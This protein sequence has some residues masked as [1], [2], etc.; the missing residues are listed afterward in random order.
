MQFFRSNNDNLS[1]NV[2]RAASPITDPITNA[3]QSLAGKV[4]FL[5]SADGAKFEAEVTSWNADVAKYV[6]DT[7]VQPINT[8]EVCLTVAAASKYGARLV[9]AGGRHGHDCLAEGA[10]VLDLSK[11]KAVHVD[12][13]KRLVTVEG[14]CKLGDM[15][16]A[17]KP[18]GLGCV[19]GT[20]PDTGVVGLST[21]GGG[22][23]LSRLHG[24]AVD[25][26]VSATVVL[27]N[28]EAITASKDE[29]ADLLWGLAGAGSNFGVVTS[30]TMRAHEVDQVFGGL[31]I[32]TAFTIRGANNVL[33]NWRDWITAAPRSLMSMAVLPCGAPV[34]PMVIAETDKA[35]VP[36][37]EGD[38]VRLRQIPS[39]CSLGRVGSFG[40]YASIKQMKR[41]QYHSELQAL[42]EPMQASGHYYDASCLVP[43]LSDEVI[44]TLTDFTRAQNVNK[45]ASI[46]IF[47]M[48]AA[49][50]DAPLDSTA[51]YG[52]GRKAGAFWIIIEGKF[53]PD[54]EGANRAAV[55]DWVKRLRAALAKFDVSD[56]AHT[57]DGNMES[58]LAGA[59][60]IFGPN[61]ERLRAVKA[62]YDPTNFFKCNRNIEPA[63]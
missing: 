2:T 63:A 38:S 53:E 57:L 28:G 18:H 44:A 9:I 26:F 35:V 23:Y 49:I 17:C 52:G 6:P 22:G 16:A 54:E 13:E 25:N 59:R 10:L 40:S 32:N 55:V 47:P 58:E 20:N 61:L 34:V 46:I 19:T 48:G 33:A 50:A 3:R 31:L 43:E 27:A 41:M 60:A 4:S 30:L 42:L 62:K 11:M 21:A 5:T 8:A 15:D 14:G 24:M 51:F 56:T 1:N 36:Q 45:I 7:I 37:G 39:F 12:A 29:H